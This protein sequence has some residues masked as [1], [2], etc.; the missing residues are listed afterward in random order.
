M[1]L[2]RASLL[3]GGIGGLISIPLLLTLALYTRGWGHAWFFLASPVIILTVASAI[4]AAVYAVLPS[5]LRRARY[6]GAI[7]GVLAFLA[8]EILYA[9]VLNFRYL[10]FQS[11][12]FPLFPF[13]ASLIVIGWIPI[14]GGVFAGTKAERFLE[15]PGS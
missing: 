7:A 10:T 1:V 9:S 3:V 13:F 14:L 2:L 8:Y 6:A 12:P 11:Y 15:R 4:F 5:S